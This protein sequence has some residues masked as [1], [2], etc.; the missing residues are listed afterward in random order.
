MGSGSPVTIDSSTA[1]VPSSTTPSTGIFSPG[2]KRSLSPICT[3]SC[4]TS[5][6]CTRRAVVGASFSRLLS[7]LDVW[8]RASSSRICPTI[9]STV[10]TAAVSKQTPTV[11]PCV[12][13]ESG[14]IPGATVATTLNAYAAPTPKAMSVNILSFQVFIEFQPRTR[15]G[16]PAHST[17]G[18]TRTS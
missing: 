5:S 17:T 1:H 6:S 13:N 9:T 18:V 12:R 11:A 7:A 16:Q 4:A 8:L 14:K 2:R 3:A 10:M 15:K